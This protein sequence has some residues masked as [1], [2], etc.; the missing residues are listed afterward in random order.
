MN[1]CFPVTETLF[2]IAKTLKYILAHIAEKKIYAYKLASGLDLEVYMMLLKLCAGLI[3]P[4]WLT[5]MA[6][7]Q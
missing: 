4:P 5:K 6:T 7:R 3:F 1:F 2:K